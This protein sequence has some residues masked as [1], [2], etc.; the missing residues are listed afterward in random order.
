MLISHFAEID[1]YQVGTLL[2]QFGPEL[3]DPRILPALE[4]LRTESKGVF[5]G[6]ESAALAEIQRITLGTPAH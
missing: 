5:S 6:D 3:A 4:A 1:E 2:Q